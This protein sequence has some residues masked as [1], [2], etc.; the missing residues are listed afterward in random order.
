MNN[1][2]KILSSKLKYLIKLILKPILYFFFYPIKYLVKK[3]NIVLLSGA[4]DQFY[5]GNSRYLYEFLSKDSKLRVYYYTNSKEV[6]KYLNLHNLKFISLSRPFELIILM[7]QAKIVINSGDSYL[8]FFGITDISSVFKICLNH[9]S[10][11]KIKSNACE[12]FWKEHVKKSAKFDFINFPSN[13]TS[14][15]FGNDLYN[16]PVTKIISLGYPRCDQFFNKNLVD[17]SF[18]KKEY[19]KEIIGNEF[20]INDKTLLYTPTW[21]PYDYEFPLLKM[22]GLELIHFNKWLQT[23]NLY[24]VY[25][26]HLS[27][28]MYRKYGFE[29]DRIRM[30]NRSKFN[31]FDINKLMMEVDILLNDY[32]TS[33]VDFSIL[34]KP[35]IFFLPDANTYS[36]KVDFIDEYRDSMPGAEIKDYNSFIEKIEYIL[37]NEKNY[38]S[39]YKSRN[40]DLLEKYLYNSYVNSSNNF[41]QFINKIISL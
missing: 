13:Y 41:N 39:D 22:K 8:N 23:N 38:L 15:S 17:K 21:R 19:L 29:A 6:Q 34:G 7:L 25:T 14:N 16:L 27:I 4:D 20:S 35:Q 9:G 18:T 30:I 24:F 11:P 40:I 1:I 26:T 33:S 12:D 36:K 10:G 5:C 2:I 31:L 3:S 37:N 28:D 32:S